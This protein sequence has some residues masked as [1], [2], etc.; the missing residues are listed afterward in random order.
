MLQAKPKRLSEEWRIA[1]CDESGETRYQLRM[2]PNSVATHIPGEH[3][4][5]VP[6]FDKETGKAKLNQKGKQ[7]MG[8]SVNPGDATF[9]RIRFA[10]VGLEGVTDS[11][12]NAP[13]E[14]KYDQVRISGKNHKCL[15]SEIL[16]RLPDALY[17]EILEAVA[18]TD[19][20]E[21]DEEKDERDNVDFTSDLS[22]PTD[23][24]DVAIV[25]E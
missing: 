17:T 4:R 16:D 13:L 8:H 25:P 11:E 21:P 20:P 1:K 18:E 7:K 15:R 9:D 5:E 6:L 19:T 12:T 3:L 2:L 14:L 24:T 23:S 22:T 10:L